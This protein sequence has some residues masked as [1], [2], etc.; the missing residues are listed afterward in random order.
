MCVSL[1]NIISL[2]WPRPWHCDP[3]ILTL[4][5]VVC[6]HRFLP[7]PW[8]SHCDPFLLTL[9]DVFC[10]HWFLPW[11]WPS[12]CDPFLLTMCDV[13]CSHLLASRSSR[14]CRHDIRIKYLQSQQ[15]EGTFW[16]ICPNFLVGQWYYSKCNAFIKTDM[17]PANAG[18]SHVG[19]RVS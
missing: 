18:V 2:Q 10:S 9:C 4:C 3:F 11:P 8:P 17:S 7:W 16:N 1:L 14:L 15:S 5:D 13:V 12:H 19:T 6:S